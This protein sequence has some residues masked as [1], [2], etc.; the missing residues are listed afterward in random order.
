MGGGG[1]S[2]FK[3][4]PLPWRSDEFNNIYKEL[5]M[6]HDRTKSNRSR[7]QMLRRVQGVE[8]SIRQ[9]PKVD[10]KNGWVFK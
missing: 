1:G 9:K 2:F 3:I 4:K 10:E 5:D 7:R 6:K 8:M